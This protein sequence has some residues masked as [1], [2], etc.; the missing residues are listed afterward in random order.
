MSIN[1]TIM[2]VRALVILSTFLLTSCLSLQKD[3][4]GYICIGNKLITLKGT[5]NTD[6]YRITPQKPPG[7]DNTISIQF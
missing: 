5:V 2:I 4:N 3:N 1:F 6:D 7:L